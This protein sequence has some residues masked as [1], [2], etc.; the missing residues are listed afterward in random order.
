MAKD[1]EFKVDTKNFKK[2]TNRLLNDM[3][4]FN[5]K[6]LKT[7]GALLLRTVRRI[8]PVDT[9]LL[10]KSWFVEKPVVGKNKSYVEIK[11]NVKYALPV[12]TGRRTK[13]GGFIAGRFMLKKSLKEIES[14]AVG[15]IESE[16]Q[17]FVDRNGGGK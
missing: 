5:E 9:G 10:K 2:T 17:K 12:E 11:N 1:Y 3:P 15:I 6:V 16:A 14:K 13:K 4:N 7:L 8:T